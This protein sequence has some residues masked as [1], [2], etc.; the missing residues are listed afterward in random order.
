M[1]TKV[2]SRHE[3]S[4]FFPCFG[5]IVACLDPD[6]DSLTS[7]QCS[8]FSPNIDP[9]PPPPRSLAFKVKSLVLG[10]AHSHIPYP[11]FQLP[12]LVWN[13]WNA[14]NRILV[15]SVFFLYSF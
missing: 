12:L 15:C 13:A 9:T 10:V 14:K 5:I 3:I 7:Y 2:L 8:D 4:G 6:L 11:V 1:T